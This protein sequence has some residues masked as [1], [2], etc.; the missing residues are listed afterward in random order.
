MLSSYQNMVLLLGALAKRDDVVVWIRTPDYRTQLYVSPSFEKI[1]GRKVEEMYRHPLQWSDYLLNDERTE[2][3]LESCRR[4]PYTANK[5]YNTNYYRIK[6]PLGEVRYIRDMMIMIHNHDNQAIAVAGIAE[7]LEQ[8]EWE[9]IVEKLDEHDNWQGDESAIIGAVL[10][11]QSGEL[12]PDLIPKLQRDDLPQHYVFLR[13]GNFI[14]LTKRE[15]EVLKY[16]LHGKSAKETGK[17]LGISNRTVEEFITQ[18][19][20]KFKCQN[21]SEIFGLLHP[22]SIEV[23]M[24]NTNLD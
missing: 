13:D 11:H 15:I 5:S 1:W 6:H 19:K 22:A 2:I 4:N 17:I 12:I 14:A 3:I 21:K 20:E 23:V 7:Q 10:A 8:E 16:L 18:L 24:H 9:S